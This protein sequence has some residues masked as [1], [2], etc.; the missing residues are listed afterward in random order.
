MKIILKSKKCFLVY[1]TFAEICPY[2]GASTKHTYEISSSPRTIK[3]PSCNS[4]RFVHFTK[5]KKCKKVWIEGRGQ[6]TQKNVLEQIKLGR[7]NLEDSNE[8]KTW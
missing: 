5:C 4:R 8:N 2:C 3:I 6:I 1:A 7:Y